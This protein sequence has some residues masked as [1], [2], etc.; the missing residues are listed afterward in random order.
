[1]RY[2]LLLTTASTIRSM[3]DDRLKIAEG[4]QWHVLHCCQR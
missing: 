2:Q 4:G 3:V 1:M